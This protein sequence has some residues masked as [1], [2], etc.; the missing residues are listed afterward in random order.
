MKYFK[1]IA[2][3]VAT[4]IAGLTMAACSSDDYEAEKTYTTR[5]KSSL[6]VSFGFIVP[7]EGSNKSD[8]VNYY[9]S[10]KYVDNPDTGMTLDRLCE[11]AFPNNRYCASTTGEDEFGRRETLSLDGAAVDRSKTYILSENGSDV[12]E[13]GEKAYS[14]AFNGRK[15]EVP[16]SGRG[17]RENS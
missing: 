7:A 4:A 12:T 15:Y 1:T 13:D 17:Q 14:W 3:M 5:S 11:A 9:S 6:L 8:L 16:G 10:S 2:W